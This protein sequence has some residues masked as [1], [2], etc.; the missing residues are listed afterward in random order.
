GIKDVF[1]N[2]INSAGQKMFVGFDLENANLLG[3][4]N[5]S[6]LSNYSI[7]LYNNGSPVG[8]VQTGTGL[9]SAN[10]AA[11]SGSGR[12][13]LGVITDL[14][15]DEVVLNVASAR[16]TTLTKV[17]GLTVKKFC[18]SSLDCNALTTVGEPGHPIYINLSRTGSSA[19]VSLRA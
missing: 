3:L 9:L 1:G 11:V 6:L 13:T 4:L 12:S 19:L 8:G 15:F 18:S 5:A 10:L 16:S 17:Y 2:A 7:Q 14:E